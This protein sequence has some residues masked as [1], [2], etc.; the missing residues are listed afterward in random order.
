MDELRN[1]IKDGD[2]IFINGDSVV[3]KIIKFF[4][5]SKFSHVGIAFWLED[6]LMMVEAQTGTLRRIINFSSF[7]NYADI[8]VVSSPKSWNEVSGKALSKVGKAH[9]STIEAIGVGCREFMLINFNIDLKVID[10]RGEICSEFV[11]KTYDLDEVMI[12][13]QKL[14]EN[15]LKLGMIIR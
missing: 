6:R 4:T 9:Y 13:P 7:Y 11:A 10:V 1:K 12:S 2:I 14:Y 3:S 15:L 5:K 8:T